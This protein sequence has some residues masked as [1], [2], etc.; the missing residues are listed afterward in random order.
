MA[1]WSG[2]GSAGSAPAIPASAPAPLTNAQKLTEAREALHL[3]LTGQNM[4]VIGYAER[5]V[6]YTST[7]IADLRAYIA[8]LEGLIDPVVR[9]RPFHVFW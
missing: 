9:R 2:T 7:N 1:E 3:L 4:V 8:E 5:R 6:T